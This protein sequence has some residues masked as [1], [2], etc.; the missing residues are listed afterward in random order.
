MP[1]SAR[2]AAGTAAFGCVT[3]MGMKAVEDISGRIAGQQ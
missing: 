1:R 3:G 2:E